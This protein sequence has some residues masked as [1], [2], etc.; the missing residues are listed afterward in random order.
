MKKTIKVQPVVHVSGPQWEVLDP[1]NVELNFKI[2][3]KG[4]FYSV[5]QV[6]DLDGNSTEYGINKDWEWECYDNYN[7]YL[8]SIIDDILEIVF[9]NE[10]YFFETV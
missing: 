10:E 3:K 1:R 2:F 7:S 5:I 6:S 4:G 8:N 9:D